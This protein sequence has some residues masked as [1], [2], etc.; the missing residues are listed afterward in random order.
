MKIDESKMKES[1]GILK[2]LKH[3]LFSGLWALSLAFV[4]LNY[5]SRILFIKSLADP[6]LIGYI[7]VC[8]VLG[9][10]YGERFIETLAVKTDNWFDIR[11]FFRF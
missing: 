10:L 5:F 1:P 7:L 8:M 2:R 11:K 3:A 9:Y 6:L 4:L